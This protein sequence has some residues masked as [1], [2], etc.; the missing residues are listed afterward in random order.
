MREQ[1]YDTIAGPLSKLWEQ[2]ST[3]NQQ[4]SEFCL[5]AKSDRFSNRI[6]EDILR[7]WNWLT[8][9]FFLSSM[10]PEHWTDYSRFLRGL[11][12]RMQR[13]AEQPAARELERIATLDSA[14]SPTFYSCYDRHTHSAA[15]LSYGLMVQEL[16]LSIFA[17]RLAI[18][19]RSSAKKLSA[20]AG[21]L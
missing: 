3:L 7:E 17:P 20:A 1:L 16:R 19:G 13:I 15:W 2:L 11:L 6:A 18:K 5:T 21:L 9:P 12:E 10:A 14:I 4:I 8:R